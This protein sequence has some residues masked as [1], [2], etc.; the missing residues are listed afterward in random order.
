M[1]SVLIGKIS[2]T[3]GI[4]GEVK[5]Y[6]YT[7][8][9]DNLTNIKEI[10]LDSKLLIKYNIQNSRVHKNMLIVKFKEISDIDTAIKLKDKYVYI[11]R[12]SLKILEEDTYYVFDLIGIEVFDI[13]ENKIGVLSDVQNSGA[14]DVYEIKTLEDKKIYLPAIHDVIKKVDLKNKKMYVEIMKGLIWQNL[15]Y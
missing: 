3:H 7:D 9:I 14:N 15:L 6:P 11:S 8:D 10:Y 4:N 12:E 2:N 13:N 1:G 5:I